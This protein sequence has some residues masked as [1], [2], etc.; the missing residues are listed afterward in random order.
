MQAAATT[1]VKTCGCGRQYTQET[2]EALPDKKV[3][4]MEWGEV[5]E[6]RNCV[7]RSTIV[8]VLEKGETQHPAVGALWRHRTTRRVAEIRAI[9][10]PRV[11]Y[12]YTLT[13]TTGALTFAR[14]YVNFTPEPQE[15][16]T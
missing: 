8:M 9:P 10:G 14:F 4:R 15:G 3:Y 11:L 5:H 2:W 1:T 7:C 6:M 12:R 16:R 13:R